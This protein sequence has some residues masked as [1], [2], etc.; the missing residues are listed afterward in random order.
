M[1]SISQ[2][3]LY[4]F[5]IYWFRSY[6]FIYGLRG[7][8]T[9]QFSKQHFL[10]IFSIHFH[11]LLNYLPGFWFF[12]VRFLLGRI[13]FISFLQWSSPFNSLNPHKIFS[14]HQFRVSNFLFLHLN[15]SKQLWI[16]KNSPQFRYSSSQ[17]ALST[18]ESLDPRNWSNFWVILRNFHEFSWF[19]PDVRPIL[20]SVFPSPSPTRRI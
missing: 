20:K 18:I 1:W 16:F 4:R 12:S 7:C 17:F 19:F 10:F 5:S 6:R 13:I 8:C 15:W 11:R 2:V 3:N 9:L 14:I